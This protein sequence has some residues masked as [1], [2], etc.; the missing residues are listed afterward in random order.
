MALL[1][2]VASG[3]V[4]YAN[5]AN[6]N[7]KGVAT[8]YGGRVL[9]YAKSLNWAI[10]TTFAGSLM[11]FF[12][13]ARLLDLFSGK[14]LVSDAVLADP[15]FLLVVAASAAITV[16]LATFLGMPI[17]TTHSLVGAL[18]GAGIA[19]H[20]LLSYAALGRSFLLP[21]LL[22]PAVAVV[23]TAVLYSILHRVRKAAAIESTMCLCVG[24]RQVA[25]A[26]SPGL[27]VIHSTGV[28]VTVKEEER[29][30]QIYS[31]RVAGVNLQKMMDV[32]H[33]ISAGAVSFAR[34]FNDTP[35]IAALLLAAGMLSPRASVF[36]VGLGMAIGG[37]LHSKRIARRMS[38]EITEMN[39]GQAFTG[40]GV[41]AALVILGSLA[42]LPLSTT[43]VSCG[44]LFGIGLVQGKANM[45]TI[46]QILVAWI[47]TL[48]VAAIL[49]ALLWRLLR[50]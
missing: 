41:T 28:K 25:V 44:S 40:N 16:I 39:P 19:S 42:G 27:Y 47:A 45:R 5:G 12:L 33:G 34:G 37:A 26:G 29:C 21:L 36:L 50:S 7:F 8:L 31:G 24:E 49:S 32:L 13:A 35:K 3:F 18:A 15:A 10:L 48:P 23:M 1:L 38:F 6:D 17:S 43:H 30:R 11:S 22:G 4:A 20:G 46:A 2:A 9:S 14:G